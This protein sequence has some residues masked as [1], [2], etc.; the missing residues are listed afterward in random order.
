MGPRFRDAAKCFAPLLTA[1][2][3]ASGADITVP[4][5]TATFA[6]SINSTGEIAGYA[7]FASGTSSPQGFLRR[8]D[9]ALLLFS[10]PGARETVPEDI[11]D[12]GQVAGYF[13]DRALVDHGFL[14]NP[15]QVYTIF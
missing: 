4:N 1:V 2:A 6:V 14:L 7:N 9:G 15:G 11:N 12:S 10:A 8:P 5:A 3:L 13:V